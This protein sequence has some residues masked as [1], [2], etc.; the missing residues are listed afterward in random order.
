MP[1]ELE[2]KEEVD[3]TIQEWIDA[4]RS[5][6]YKQGRGQLRMGKVMGPYGLQ[7]DK[8]FS[9]CCLGVL[10]EIVGTE[11][12]GNDAVY[13]DIKSYTT[14]PLPLGNRIRN[15]YPNLLGQHEPEFADLANISVL[16]LESLN[17]DNKLTFSEIAD[18]IERRW[19]EQQQQQSNNSNN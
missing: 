6:E 14:L 18:E 4:L 5:G 13:E 17:D 7:S 15:Y 16:L 11:W 9:Y 3:A 10:C 19:R 12:E 8:E 2:S 1:R